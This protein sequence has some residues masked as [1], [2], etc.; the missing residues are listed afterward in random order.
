MPNIVKNYETTASMGEAEIA[1]K[2]FNEFNNALETQKRNLDRSYRNWR[3]YHAV[4]EGQ[5]EE[6]LLQ[7]LHAEGRHYEQFNIASPKVDVL[8]GALSSEKFDLDL[9]PIE[10]KKNS[11]T[12]A[13]N[14]SYSMDRDLCHYDKALGDCIKGGLVVGSDIKQK[15]SSRHDPK[16]NICFEI[17]QPGFLIRD[18]Y[19]I[20]D[21]D[22]D[23]EKAWEVFHLPAWKIAQYPNA[24]GALIEQALK[25]Y[26]KHGG[27]YDEYD[28]DFYSQMNLGFKGHL[29][30]VIEYHY[31]E[32]YQTTR[33][34][35][36]ILGSKRYIPFPITRDEAVLEAYMIKNNIDPMTLEVT[37][38]DDR[39]HK[40][41][42]ISPELLSGK[43]LD[44]K[45]R[46]SATQ[47]KR[48]PYYHFTVDRT[49][50][51]DKGIIDDIYDLQRA[52]NRREMKLSD[53]IDSADGGGGVYSED[54]WNTPEKKAEL[55]RNATNPRYRTFA[56]GDE[57][58]KG[59]LVERLNQQVSNPAIIDQ[60]TRFWDVVDRISKVP[61]AMEAMT[62]SS[63]ESGILF[64]RKLQVARMGILTLVDRVK[65]LRKNI[66]EGYYEQWQVVDAYNMM[67]REFTSLD[68][69]VS[70]VLNQRVMN[71]DDGRIYV[72][73]R[74]S[75]IPRSAVII[76]ESPSSPTKLMQR[77]ALYSELFDRAVQTA[78]EASFIFFKELMKTMDLDEDAQDELRKFSM[79]ESI[80]SYKRID[81]EIATLD[82]T[83]Q[84]AILA[85]MQTM[86]SIEQITG[87]GQQ[88]PLPVSQIP[89]DEIPKAVRREPLPALE[90]NQ[91]INEENI[92]IPS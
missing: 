38:Y 91:L 40:L 58:A 64:D 9:K 74:P 86:F 78:P 29:Y 14:I 89:E 37:P 87:G 20:T 31:I 51:V 71:P 27:E 8:A 1:Q 15:M 63:S 25:L 44:G 52:L 66:F 68:G 82:A 16:T 23:C 83:M 43:L 10:G 77:R 55:K 62:Q 72:Q 92:L 46:I 48:L 13:C 90:D 54:V 45:A 21:D 24:K 70:T 18:P 57:I 6:S 12:E 73:N 30:R 88:E 34:I 60:I 53:L 39:I 19:W 26:Q 65:E 84:Q 4:D 85:K 49:F 76:T 56:D 47:P 17:V 7:D 2:I 79:L 81:T 11:L 22:R 42:T 80:R 3:I 59:K 33:L 75:M 50:G 67:E 61:A 32:H 35:G 41:M 5:A 36:E 28:T 69:K